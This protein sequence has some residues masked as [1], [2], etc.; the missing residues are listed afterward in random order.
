MGKS[1]YSLVLSD[2]VIAML[3]NLAYKKGVSRSTLVNRVLAEY[4]GYETPEQRLKKMFSSL[5]QIIMGEQRMR[6]LSQSSDK[7]FS[8]TSALNYKYSPRI[9]YLVEL[10][11][12]GDSIGELSITYRTSKP[13]LIDA[14]SSFFA[15]WIALEKAYLPY[16]VA[17]S[18]TDGKLKRKLRITQDYESLETLAET[19]TSYVK[20]I[21]KLLNIYIT[22]DANVRD[23]MLSSRFLNLDTI[24]RI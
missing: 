1:I 13:E 12:E 5:E 16:D 8:I 17:Y 14:I 19:I 15:T 10:D 6:L 22:E 11:Y 24:G 20:N 4:V 2:E 23:K 3:D 21:D 7:A 9:T 18:V